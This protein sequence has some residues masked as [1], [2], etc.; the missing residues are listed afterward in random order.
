[1]YIS[2]ITAILP[3]YNEEV[4]IGSVVLRTRKYADRVIVI[5]DGSLD[6]T[7][8]VAEMAG[9]EVIRHPQNM[10]KGAALKTGFEALSDLRN[11][12]YLHLSGGK[13]QESSFQSQNGTK[14]IV[15]IDTD[16]QHDPADIPKLVEP[17]LKDE[18]D[19]VNGSR[20]LNGN[21]K[22]TPLYRRLGQ[23]I[24]DKATNLDS[25]LN[26]TDSQSGFRAFNPDIG[27]VFRFRANG[28][29]IESEM[30]AD[31]AAAG[32]RIKEVE[33]GVRYDVNC[34]TE[35]PVAHGVRVLV[36]VL[37]DMEFKR[38][39]YY[40]TIP[41][42]VMSAI[43]VGMGLDFL[44]AF[45]HGESLAYG[46]TLLM[47]LLTLIGSFTALTGIILHTLSRLID[48]AKV[49]FKASEKARYEHRYSSGNSARDN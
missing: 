48:E 41:G 21:K 17:I 28:L 18:A 23:V 43:G 27:D 44:R 11:E 4:S 33:I 30:L 42:I 49:E 34:S 16:G 19:M 40:F 32:I 20:Y 38:P 29:A 25:G 14:V 47:V 5:D 37:H 31:A 15:T 10:G 12:A 2:G 1:M 9:A 26:V 46:P 22:D 24:L 6:N 45:Y 35:N 8:E 36:K 39:L 13:D 7:A 3:A